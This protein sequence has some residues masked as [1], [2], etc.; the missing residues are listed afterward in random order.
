MPYPVSFFDALRR[1]SFR[2]TYFEVDD[3]DAAGGRRVVVHE[4]PLRDEP[5]SEDLGR[6]AREFSVRGYII[7]GREYDYFQAR[8][9]ILAALEAYGPGELVHPWHGEV[10]VVVDD[11]RLRES[12][13]QGGLLELDIRF[14][15]AGQL[16]NPTARADTALGVNTAAA[17]VRQAL[18][19]QFLAVFAP[20]LDELAGVSAALDDAARLAMEYLGLPQSLI[21]EGLAWVQ[22]LLATPS[23]LF[24]ALTGLFGGLLG[25]D[26]DD[27]AYWPA[28]PGGNA[29]PGPLSQNTAPLEKIMGG[30]SVLATA[31]ER[32]IRDTVAEIV[33]TETVAS[34]SRR[35]YATADDALA[36]RG[37]VVAGLDAIE[38]V[39][40][41]A[42][43]QCLAELRRA[44]VTDLTV[45]GAELPQLRSVTLPA[46]V[47][48]LVAAYRIHGH[49]GRAEEILT[50][51]R[52]RHPG[53]VPGGIPLEVLGE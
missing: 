12:S 31:P 8:A 36:E 32:V 6:R 5:Y 38:P 2:G 37:A 49:A 42:L 33:V 20:E 4:Y 25:N 23:A 3:V 26:V 28:A 44:V 14:R 22:S 51:N 9:D 47:P 41:D 27:A 30:S 48:A 18:K 10:S 40:D 7:Q 21:A 53:R 29:P 11:Y 17:S 43:F 39:A 15:E 19:A 45:R 24:D 16:E 35:D 13:E 1:A 34:T 46:T 52:I 50:R